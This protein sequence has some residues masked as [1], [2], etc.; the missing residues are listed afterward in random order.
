MRSGLISDM[1]TASR[2]GGAVK[3][4]LLESQLKGLERN[5]LDETVLTP[6]DLTNIRKMIVVL[7]SADNLPSSGL[8]AQSLI[9]SLLSTP[10]G[11]AGKVLH[12]GIIGKDLTSKAASAALLGSGK[13]QVTHRSI[14]DATRTLLEVQDELIK[15]Q[16]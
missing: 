16:Q 3:G 14:A 13:K 2:K 12:M 7:K 6:D 10:L 8:A 15:E 5:G 9:S 1:L 4:N 11:S